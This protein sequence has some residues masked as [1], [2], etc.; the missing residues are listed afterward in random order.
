M[1][2]ERQLWD[3]VEQ[4]KQQHPSADAGDYTVL[5][6]E[7]DPE[8]RPD[9][10]TWVPETGTLTYDL[11]DAQREAVEALQTDADLVALTA[12]YGSGKSIL[13]ARYL[14]KNAL[15]YPESRFMAM[16]IDFSKARDSTFRTLFEQLPGDRTAVVTSSY[17]G[18][19]TSPIVTDYNR[20]E[21]RLTLINDT[22][23]ICGSADRWNRYAGISLSGFWGDEVSHYSNL[24]DL[25][26]MIGSRL[27]G[28]DGPHKQLWTTTGNGQNNAAFDVIE[29]GKDANDEPL[30]LEVEKVQASTLENPYLDDATKER[31]KRQYGSTSREAEALHGGFSSSGGQLLTRDQLQFVDNTDLEIEAAEYHVGVDLSYTGSEAKAEANDS[32]YTAVTLVLFDRETRQATCVDFQR[33]RGKTLRQTLQWLADQLE[34]IPAPVV[35]IEEVGASKWFIQEARTEIPGRVQAVTPGNRSKESRLTEMGILFERGDV[36]LL[37]TDMDE[38]LGFDPRWRPFVREWVQLGTN[39]SSPD[40]LDSAYYALQDLPLGGEKQA[41][42]GHM[43]SCDPWG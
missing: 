23:I 37:N 39:D 34:E 2:T 41:Q 29:R 24:H 11:W 12:G 18:P 40:I 4:Q 38:N 20:Q 10:M 19:E 14:I 17:N 22:E 35:K 27:R 33:T 1:S 5:W 42:I 13:G 15:E 26:E 21:H 30:G 16:G 7:A 32:D 9:G 8:A 3:K 36:S 43:E 25:L 31:F 6:G 28:V